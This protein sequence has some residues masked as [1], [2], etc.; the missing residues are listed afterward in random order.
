MNLVFAPTL[1]VQ[2]AVPGIKHSCGYPKHFLYNKS[3][4]TTSLLPTSCYSGT[5]KQQHLAGIYP[6]TGNQGWLYIHYTHSSSQL[7]AHASTVHWAAVSTSLSASSKG[8]CMAKA[9]SS[10]SLCSTS[11]QCLRWTNTPACTSPVVPWW[12]LGTGRSRKGHSCLITLHFK[13]L[14]YYKRETW[15][16]VVIVQE[17]KSVRDQFLSD[18]L[19]QFPPTCLSFSLYKIGMRRIT[20]TKCFKPT[21]EKWL[22]CFTTWYVGNCSSTRQQVN[23]T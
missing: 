4:T 3:S 22:E 23:Y 14:L 7:N 8:K 18:L 9:A 20:S 2:H 19:Q 1:Q 21:S 11:W 15:D 12:R 10:L 13:K 16:T 6:F 17:Q 5:K